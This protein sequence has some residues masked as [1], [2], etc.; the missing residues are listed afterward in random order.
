MLSRNGN[1]IKGAEVYELSKFCYPMNDRLNA[2]IGVYMGFD[3]SG[4][5]SKQHIEIQ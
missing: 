2:F 1:F 3:G 4:K 5:C